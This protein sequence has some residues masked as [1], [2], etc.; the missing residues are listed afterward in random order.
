[1]CGMFVKWRIWQIRE[2]ANSLNQF[3]YPQPLNQWKN[4]HCA[5]QYAWK[6]T[7]I[8]TFGFCWKKRRKDKYFFSKPSVMHLRKGQI[9]IEAHSSS[10]SLS[11][12]RFFIFLFLWEQ[13]IAFQ[14]TETKR[15]QESLQWGKQPAREATK[16]IV[17]LNIFS[18]H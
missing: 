5:R 13:G 6:Y 10:V 16:A 14:G 7:E 2:G 3:E 8:K 12:L 9:L 4:W 18:T 11:F 17:L 1:M 15:K